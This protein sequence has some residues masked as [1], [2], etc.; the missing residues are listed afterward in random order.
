[1]YARVTQFSI[2]PEKFNDFV[3][4]LK[5]AIPLVRQETGFRGLFLLRVENSNPPDVRLA[6]FWE[7]QQAMRDSE[8]NLYTEE[9]LSRVLA[10]AH[11]FP[12]MREEEVILHDFASAAVRAAFS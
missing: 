3:E 6:T 7:T 8:R 9:V 12:I 4:H 11:G 2:P 10:F 5:S 1:M